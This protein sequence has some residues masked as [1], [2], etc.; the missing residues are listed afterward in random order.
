MAFLH[1]LDEVRLEQNTPAAP[2]NFV[3]VQKAVSEGVDKLLVE[4]GLNED[5]RIEALVLKWNATYLL[6]HSTTK[7]LKETVLKVANKLARDKN[8]TLAKAAGAT[9]TVRRARISMRRPVAKRRQKPRETVA[10]RRHD[11]QG[12]GLALCKI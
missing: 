2:A 9:Q 3:R 4:K 6:L 8:Q 1:K 12:R 10:G 7:A 11:S 5:A